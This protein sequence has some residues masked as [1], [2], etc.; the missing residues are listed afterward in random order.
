[1]KKNGFVFVGILA[2]MLVLGI[3][4]ISCDNGTPGGGDDIFIITVTGLTD[5]VGKTVKVYFGW[6]QKINGMNAFNSSGYHHEEVTVASDGTVSADYSDLLDTESIKNMRDERIPIR[7]CL[8]LGWPNDG[9]K[10]EETYLISDQEI[11]VAYST[12]AFN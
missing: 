6:S 8:D 7:I 11:T 10:S 3:T 12:E 2:I 5:Y 1:M 9:L 4:V